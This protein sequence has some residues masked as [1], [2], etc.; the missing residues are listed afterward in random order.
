MKQEKN[1]KKN[2]VGRPPSGKKASRSAELGTKPGDMRKSYLVNIEQ[3][4]KIDAIAYWDRQSVKD[5]V[6]EA[7]GDRIK[8]FEKK[9]GSLKQRPKK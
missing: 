6:G 9:N 5:V 7:F 4:E 8:K 1:M 3:A 2:P